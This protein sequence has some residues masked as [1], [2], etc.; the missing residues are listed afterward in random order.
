[1]NIRKQKRGFPQGRA[2]KNEKTAKRFFLRHGSRGA[3]FP[4]KDR[5]SKTM[6]EAPEK[7]KE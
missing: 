7:P 6:T 4:V 1:M 3:N 2:Q 5:A